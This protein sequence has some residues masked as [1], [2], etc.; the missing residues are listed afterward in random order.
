MK[1]HERLQPLSRDHH[2]VLVL[3]QLLKKDAPP[4][5]GLP[6]DTEGKARYALD[7]YNERILTHFYAEEKLLFP[8]IEGYSDE[9][10]RLITELTAEHSQIVSLFEKLK[11]G[12]EP[13]ETMDFIG[14]LMSHH[15]RKE[16]RELFELVQAEISP[17][18]LE[19]LS[20]ITRK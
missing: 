12:I 6:R 10:D 19:K 9:I 1:R 5:K 2:E 4:Y 15:V 8:A 7:F 3:A 16:E 14:R 18:I 11:L 17:G 20:F 13:R